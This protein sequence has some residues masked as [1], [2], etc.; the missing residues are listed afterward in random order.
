M[1]A[2]AWLECTP[3][4]VALSLVDTRNQE[5]AASNQNQSILSAPQKRRPPV[6]VHFPTRECE[7][8]HEGGDASSSMRPRE[9]VP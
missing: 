7:V 4:P 6:E 3:K 9:A 2:N 5:A 1:K 8:D